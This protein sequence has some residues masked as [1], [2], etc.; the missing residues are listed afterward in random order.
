MEVWDPSL[1]LLEVSHFR[2]THAYSPENCKTCYFPT[3]FGPNWSFSTQEGFNC[4]APDFRVSVY[5]VTS[6]LCGFQKAG[7]MLVCYTSSLS[8]PRWWI[9][10][11]FSVG[12]EIA[13]LPVWLSLT[14]STSWSRSATILPSLD[15]P[16]SVLQM[17]AET[18]I[19]HF[20]SILYLL[21]WNRLLIYSPGW[22][23]TYSSIY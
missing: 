8:G 7:E 5:A 21:V 13:V 14:L 17:I 11:S 19:L 12:A 2:P 4:Y 3:S 22:P 6:V 18:F 10:S 15:H 23:G 9:P 1:W 16:P 20:L